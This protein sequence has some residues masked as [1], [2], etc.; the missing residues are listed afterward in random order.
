MGF[1]EGI[2]RQ[3][4]AAAMA[5]WA[6]GN[7]SNATD[8]SPIVEELLAAKSSFAEL[9]LSLYALVSN[10]VFVT[11]LCAFA[12]YKIYTLLFHPLQVRCRQNSCSP[13]LIQLRF[14]G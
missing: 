13:K 4:S 7:D 9:F 14:C 12:A 8:Q 3:F 10:R 1:L 2:A 11:V 5:S 6:S